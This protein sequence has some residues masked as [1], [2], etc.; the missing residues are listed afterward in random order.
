LFDPAKD[1]KQQWVGQLNDAKQREDFDEV[2]R[3]ARQFVQKDLS[4]VER[5]DFVDRRAAPQSPH[6]GD[7]P[8]D[9]RKL[10]T[11]EADPAGLPAG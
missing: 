4:I 6:H 1:T 3:I 10:V 5:S 9:H 2:E 7:R 8:R 11:Q